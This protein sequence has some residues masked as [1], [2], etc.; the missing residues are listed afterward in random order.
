MA[1]I[2]SANTTLQMETERL[3]FPAIS[4]LEKPHKNAAVEAYFLGL[5][6]GF[7]LGV[8]KA[9]GHISYYGRKQIKLKGRSA[10]M[11]DDAMHAATRLSHRSDTSA[12]IFWQSFY[13]GG[14]VI[15]MSTEKPVDEAFSQRLYHSINTH[16]ESYQ[17]GREDAFYQI[18]IASTGLFEPTRRFEE[19][20]K[21]IS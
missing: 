18:S 21:N 1:V 15:N 16:Q 9:R 8:L 11:F 19:Y 12:L 20:F 14:D 3:G 17:I 13:A 2:Q 6:E 7:T 10:K 4:L 5:I